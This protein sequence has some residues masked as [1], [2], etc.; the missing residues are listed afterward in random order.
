M[1]AML[2]PRI[3]AVRIHGAELLVQGV[4]GVPELIN[5]SSHGVFI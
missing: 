4:P 5:D 3:V 2:E 1:K